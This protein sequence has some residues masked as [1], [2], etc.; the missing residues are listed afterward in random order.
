MKKQKDSKR[1]IE[2]TLT[3]I[4]PAV[5]YIAGT[6]NVLFTAPHSKNHKRPNL[7]G[8]YKHEEP[9]TD[10]IV[11]A[12]CESTGAHGIV[13][14]KTVDFDPNW[15]KVEKNPFK[16]TARQLVE[17]GVEY[18]FDIHGLSDQHSYD[19]AIYYMSR[20]R[21]SKKIGYELANALNQGELKG[22]LF[23]MFNFAD[24]QQETITEYLL[25][26]YKIAGLQLELAR[27]I[28]EDELLQREFVRLFSEFVKSL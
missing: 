1:V 27:Y 14:S 21:K 7:M 24:D 4:N 6:T 26:N 22:V 15:H 18:V 23:Q 5:E 2:A 16:E 3:D 13:L 19:L 17:S 11:R 9:Y 20:F 25:S 12:L 10:E 28:R 8:T